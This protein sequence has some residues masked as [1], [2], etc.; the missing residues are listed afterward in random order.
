MRSLTLSFSLHLLAGLLLFFSPWA[1]P[2]LPEKIRPVF[3]IS[4]G[5]ASSPL[6]TSLSKK[7]EEKSKVLEKKVPGVE[8]EKGIEIILGKR[9]E[10]RLKEIEAKGQKLEYREE[11]TEKEVTKESLSLEEAS[12]RISEAGVEATVISE[13]GFVFGWYFTLLEKRIT[14]AWQPPAGSLSTDKEVILS[15]SLTREGKV[16]NI[17]IKKSSDFPSFDHSAF[18]AIEDIVDLPPLPSIWDKEEL[19][20]IV[21]FKAL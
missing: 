2:H 10:E 3:L 20:I 17:L 19:Q 11:K 6:D 8:E 5:R 12:A 9:V 13:A 15:F 16:K 21:T 18:R 7:R 4:L 14:E 1:R